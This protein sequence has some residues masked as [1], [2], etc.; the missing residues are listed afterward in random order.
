M[1][2]TLPRDLGD[3]LWLRRATPA[4]AEQLSTFNSRIHHAPGSTEPDRRVA[5]WTRDLLTRPPPGFDAGDFTIVE[6]RG[7]GAIVSSL[8]LISQTW[9]YGGVPFGVGRTELVGTDPSYRRRGLVRTQ[10]ELIHEWSAERGQR[11]QA[12]SGI[13]FF[14]RQFGYEMALT[15]EGWWLL[16]RSVVPPLPSSASEPFKIRPATPDDLAF[17]AGTYEAGQRRYVVSCVRREANWR[18][19]LTGRSVDSGAWR[20]LRVIEDLAGDRVGFV[21]H[22]P[23]LTAAGRLYAICYELAPGTS[24]LAVTPSVLRYLDSTGEGL[25]A[26]GP[27]PEF[28]SVGLGFGESHPCYPV[29]DTRFGQKG[30]PYAWYMRVPNVSSFLFHVRSALENRL[31]GSIAPG[32]TGELG[33]SFFDEGVRMR[34]ERGRIVEV[35][36]WQPS[37]ADR[38][39]LTFPGLTFLQLL[40]GYRSLADLEYA[41]ADCRARSVEA[42]VLADAL[43]P[44][45]ASEV[46]P[47]E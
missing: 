15:L 13:P 43:F 41:Y 2:T 16:H 19:E 46:W 27:S 22:L 7:T 44:K 35:V 31:A 37:Q 23:Y 12:I 25:A 10:M 32:H 47:L 40:F 8:N 29:L 17:I 20:E 42:R 38:G 9:S 18:Y 26:A 34:F 45:G 11:V 36:K 33:L 14:Y 21:A 24:W 5:A 28:Q 39:H 6:D 4:D 3:G 30:K 1:G